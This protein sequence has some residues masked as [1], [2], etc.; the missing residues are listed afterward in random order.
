MRDGLDEAFCWMRPLGG[1]PLGPSPGE[2]RQG[3][4][5]VMWLS[6]RCATRLGRQSRAVCVRGGGVLFWCSCACTC[7]CLNVPE[8]LEC[9]TGFSKA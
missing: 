4:A 5:G 9:D 3:L 8:C 1:R 7:W 2:E 6:G